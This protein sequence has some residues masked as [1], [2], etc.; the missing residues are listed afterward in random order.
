MPKSLPFVKTL[1][2]RGCGES[3]RPGTGASEFVRPQ[4]GRTNEREWMRPGTGRRHEPEDTNPN[5]HEGVP[6]L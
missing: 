1:G 5:T 3:V 2:D 4:R 6:I